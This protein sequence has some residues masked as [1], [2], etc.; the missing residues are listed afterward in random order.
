MSSKLLVGAIEEV[1]QRDERRIHAKLEDM[2]VSNGGDFLVVTNDEGVEQQF[3]FDEVVERTVADF[4]DVNPTYMKKCP[5]ELK[6]Y[7]LNHWLQERGDVQATLMVGPNGVETIH[8]PDQSII[9]IP[10]VAGMIS[11]V[12]QPTDEIVTLISDPTKF[13][14]DIMITD[15]ITVPGNGLGDRP[16]TDGLMRR[17]GEEAGT[18]QVFDITHG[19]IRIL[20]HPTQPKAPTVERYFNRLVC[21]NGL[22]MPIADRKITLRGMTVVDVLAEMEGI[23]QELM[24]DMPEAL[25]RYA[26]LSQVEIPGNPLNFIRQIGKENGIP[27]RIIQKALDY[28]GAANFGRTDIPVTSY[29][30]L[31]IFTSLANG[32]GVRYSTANKLQRLGGIFVH[33]GEEIAHRCES[34]ERVLV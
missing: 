26:D 27:D 21:T 25:Q 30:V 17:P 3:A 12:F 28:A 14:A 18:A 2:K 24:S 1:V 4:L 5:P 10:E 11:R 31:N 15:S 33:R 29:D 6:A 8:D 16:G 23:A 13:H 9:T 34:C 19:G 20:A 7:N 32:E 22:T